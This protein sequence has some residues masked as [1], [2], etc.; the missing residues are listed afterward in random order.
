[1]KDTVLGTV[2]MSLIAVCLF[3]LQLT[4]GDYPVVDTAQKKT[5]DDGTEISF[6]LPNAAFHG[7]DAQYVG[8][9]PCF[10][11]N[12]D[13]TVTDLVTGLIWQ[14]DPGDK[15]SW[16]SAVSG[17]SSFNLA[18][19][20]DWRLPTIKELYSL[21]RFNGY[22]GTSAALSRPYIDTRYFD[23][24]YGDETA[25][26]RF[27]DAQYCSATEYVGTVF[28]GDAAVFGV[29]FAD[30]RIKG[31]PKTG[32][33]GAMMFFVLYV[34][35]NTNYG[36]N[37]FVDNGNGT[38][39]DLGTGLTW[40][41]TDSGA[42]NAGPYGDGTLD[43]EQAL[44]WAEN[45]SFAGFDDWRL[46]NAKEL[47]SIVDY[48]RAP[49]VTGTAAIDV[50]FFDVTE[51]ESFFWASTTHCDGPAS[52]YGEW[53]VYVAFGR[54]MGY[55]EQPP[56]SGN[57]VYQDVH[58]AGAQRSDPKSGDPSNWP[59]GHGPQGDEVRIYNY[60]RCV[61]GGVG[62]TLAADAY[63]LSASAG[64]SITFTLDAGSG[65][66]YKSCLLGGSVSG[67]LPGTLLP[68]SLATIPLNRDWFSDYILA[69]LNTPMF[70]GF[71][72]TLDASGR[73][74]AQL[75]VPPVASSWVETNLY[76]AFT[77]PMTWDFV[78]NAVSI[79]VE[80]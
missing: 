38:V 74:T 75:N 54:A 26:E 78:S 53:G 14:Q 58:G 55:M 3:S 42:F 36:T 19:Y 80:Q 20:T 73:A 49:T 60:V 4:A 24:E 11:D 25:G 32:F 37:S 68:G 79:E 50:N 61:R 8:A 17:A 72:G 71:L 5:Y 10:Q 41:Q 23:F 63:T 29:N 56:Y 31:Y 47:Q 45:L 70:T 1:M 51:T 66:A 9:L 52:T 76:F 16:S 27:I 13:G 64:G 28:N 77:V 62:N 12:G 43:W 7:Q 6:P 69:R 57:Y 34:R 35:G 48:T 18:G 39:T 2:I 40:M 21:I 59:Y 65:Q 30:G 67:T 15:K 44:D 46:P 22:T 33:G